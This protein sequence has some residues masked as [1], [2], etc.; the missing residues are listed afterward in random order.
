[1]NE[2]KER[3]RKLAEHWRSEA[4]KHEESCFPLGDEGEYELHKQEAQTL[5]KCAHD[6]LRHLDA[7]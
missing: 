1:M 5:H 6:L 4:R 2:L 3:L 7:P